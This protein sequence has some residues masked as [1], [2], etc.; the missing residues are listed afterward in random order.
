MK[1]IKEQTEKN[2]GI[3]FAG[4]SA[5]KMQYSCLQVQQKEGYNR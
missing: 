3:S 2:L 4:E 5:G 1:N